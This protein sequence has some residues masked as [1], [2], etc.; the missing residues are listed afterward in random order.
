MPSLLKTIRLYETDDYMTMADKI[1]HS[2]E[3]NQSCTVKGFVICED[4]EPIPK[5]KMVLDHI[6]GLDRAE[7]YNSSKRRKRVKPPNSVGDF[8]AGKIF[9]WEERI[10]DRKIIILIW[11]MQ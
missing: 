4:N 5:G 6:E 3:V 9:K 10:H 2:F 7:N 8:V 11:R 1:Y